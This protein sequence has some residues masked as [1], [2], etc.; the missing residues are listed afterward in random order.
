[1]KDRRLPHRAVGTDDA[2]SALQRFHTD[3]EFVNIQNPRDRPPVCDAGE[4]RFTDRR[5]SRRFN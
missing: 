5:L 1:L 2:N 3:A 4:H